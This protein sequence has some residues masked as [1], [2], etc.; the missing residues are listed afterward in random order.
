MGIRATA[1]PNKTAKRSRDKELKS[2]FVLKTNPKPSFT[3]SHVRSAPLTTDAG[4]DF[5]LNKNKKEIMINKLIVINVPVIP[6]MA[7]RN[8]PVACPVTEA[9]SHVPWLHVVAFCK[10]FL[11]TI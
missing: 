11:G 2:S 6:T 10:S 3:L 7:I 1:P 5:I 4:L 8:P 9:E